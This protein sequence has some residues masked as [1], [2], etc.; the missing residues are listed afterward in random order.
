MGILPYGNPF[1]I[2]DPIIDED[3]YDGATSSAAGK[4]AICGK[5]FQGISIL[6]FIR[7]GLDIMEDLES[8]ERSRLRIG[9]YGNV[10]GNNS[11]FVYVE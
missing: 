6:V 4:T 9:L 2:P 5:I 3:E 11:N 7:I 1:Y 10:R 8:Q